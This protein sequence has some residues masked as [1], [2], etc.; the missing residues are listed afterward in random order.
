MTSSVLGRPR[1]VPGPRFHLH[2]LEGVAFSSA[3]VRQDVPRAPVD[4]VG[5]AA[6]TAA[7]I[8]S[9]Q[10]GCQTGVE[11]PAGA[12]VLTTVSCCV[13]VIVSV[14]GAEGSAVVVVPFAV[15]QGVPGITG[16]LPCCQT[17]PGWG[18]GGVRRRGGRGTTTMTTRDTGACGA[19]HIRFIHGLLR[20]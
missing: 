19:Q 18:G 7:V 15:A 2:L 1:K 6:V 8:P 20:N 9:I 10:I 12:V 16:V 5:H 4:A 11:P 14:S 13:A 3:S 17:V